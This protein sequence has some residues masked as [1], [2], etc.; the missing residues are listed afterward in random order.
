MV[1]PR[2]RTSLSEEGLKEIRG[3]NTQK[4]DSQACPAV[5]RISLSP[6]YSVL[7]IPN[8][9]VNLGGV[10]MHSLGTDN[11]PGRMRE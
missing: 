6:E 8:H 2:A 9:I 1:L 3:R 11:L 10:W 5:A 7:G 4:S